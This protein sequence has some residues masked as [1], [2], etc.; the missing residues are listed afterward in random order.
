MLPLVSPDNNKGNDEDGSED[1]GGVRSEETQ[2]TQIKR[3]QS[4]Q[5]RLRK[6]PEQEKQP[7]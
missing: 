1:R 4:N 3:V 6:Q 5:V 7:V 2:G